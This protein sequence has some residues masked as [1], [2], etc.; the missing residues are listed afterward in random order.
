MPA[1]AGATHKLTVAVQAS[2]VASPLSDWFTLLCVCDMDLSI[3]TAAQ[4]FVAGL[5]SDLSDLE[6]CLADGETP[7]PWRRAEAGLFDQTPGHEKLWLWINAPAIGSSADTEFVLYRGCTSPNGEDD[8]RGVV[9]GG[10]VGF[11]PCDGVSAPLTEWAGHGEASR[12]GTPSLSAGRVGSAI[13]FSGVEVRMEADGAWCLA[14]NGTVTAWYL[15]PVA[16]EGY[17]VND[18]LRSRSLSAAGNGWSFRYYKDEQ[19][20]A[21]SRY[22]DASTCK[23]RPTQNVWHCVSIVYR[24]GAGEMGVYEDGALIETRSGA[25]IV[26]ASEYL[27]LGSGQC[28]LDE[29]LVTT[30]VWTGDEHLAWY[31]MTSD[32]ASWCVCGAEEALLT[33]GL[34]PPMVRTWA[35]RGPALGM[36]G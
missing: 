26:S 8:G 3:N 29:V 12:T 23:W 14:G 10:T 32:P 36:G 27:R 19:A 25:Q 34:I 11:L 6:V 24:L 21:R 2:Q 5:A 18:L 15:V 4:S 7:T 13:D 16:G 31:R 30:E 22:D 28:T 9:S 17:T 1:P 35:R 20:E 33:V